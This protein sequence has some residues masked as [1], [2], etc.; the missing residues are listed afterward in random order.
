MAT[1]SFLEFAQEEE[2]RSSIQEKKIRIILEPSSSEYSSSLNEEMVRKF[3]T[4]MYGEDKKLNDF[5]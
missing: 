3:L 2:V 4:I 1:L 5:I